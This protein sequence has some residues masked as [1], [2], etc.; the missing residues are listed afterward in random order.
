MTVLWDVEADHP[1]GDTHESVARG[2]RA[3]VAIKPGAANGHRPDLVVTATNPAGHEAV[4]AAVERKCEGWQPDYPGVAAEDLGDRVRVRVPDAHRT[5][6]EEHFTAVMREFV[7]YVQFPR[8]IPAWE[9]ANLLARYYV[10]TRAAAIAK[11]K[12]GG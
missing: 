2:T 7:R 12:T 1:G 11:R 5:G 8:S 10:T 4:L 9:R 6:H 3:T